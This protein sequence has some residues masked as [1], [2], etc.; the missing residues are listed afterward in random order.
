MW[1]RGTRPH[2]SQQ[3]NLCM[4]PSLPS[5]CHFCCCKWMNV[6]QGMRNKA[7][8]SYYSTVHEVYGALQKTATRGRSQTG[9][10]C[11]WTAVCLSQLAF[12]HLLTSGCSFKSFRYNQW[13]WEGR[14]EE[15]LK[16]KKAKETQRP[17]VFQGLHVEVS[18]AHEIILKSKVIVENLQRHNKW[19]NMNR[20]WKKQHIIHSF[21]PHLF[22][23]SDTNRKPPLSPLRH[24]NQLKHS[25]T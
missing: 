8:L 7:D 17:L 24:N 12:M 15:L 21:L 13:E 6:F 2:A 20:G 19:E 14:G 10:S 9:F 1:S 5:S 22:V 18:R 16:M 3:S 4:P 11:P 23:L 25:N